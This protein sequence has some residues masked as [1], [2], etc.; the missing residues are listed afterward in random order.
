MILDLKD[1]FLYAEPT[2]TFVTSDGFFG[3]VN[4]NVE[5][6]IWN[7]VHG[8]LPIMTPNYSLTNDQ[9]HDQLHFQLDLLVHT[10]H[11]QLQMH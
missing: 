6:L 5:S 8:N 4:E 11:L 10:L 2:G 9:S 1:C 3:I 7:T